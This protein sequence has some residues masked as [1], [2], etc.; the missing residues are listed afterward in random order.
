[1]NKIIIIQGERRFMMRT[2]F[3]LPACAGLATAMSLIATP[4]TA[5]AAGN[6]VLV[7]TIDLPGD[8]GGH[9]DWTIYDPDTATVWLS[10]SPDQAVVV[11]DTDRNDVKGIIPDIAEPTG[12]GLTPKY[13]FIA[14]HE[15]GTVIVVDKKSLK[16]VA[17]LTPEGKGPD[18]VNFAV[19]ENHV[20]VTSDSNDATVFKV[21]APF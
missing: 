1:M 11:I 6:Y 3:T 13:A 16:K 19:K 12:I 8:K 10:Q 4:V 17:T 2:L 7:K 21:E 15:S 20:I 5:A 9:G 18:G 14:D